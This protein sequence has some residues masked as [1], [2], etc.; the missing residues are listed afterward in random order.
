MLSDCDP[1]VTELTSALTAA[2]RLVNR[3]VEIAI[4]TLAKAGVCYST[5]DVNGHVPAVRTKVIDP[6]G[7]GDALTATVLFG[8]VNDIPLDDAV[9]LGVTAASLVL[10]H[11]GT[12][13]PELSLER[14]YEELVI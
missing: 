9:R 2:R 6:T 10:R 14:L 5:Q 3:G 4:I 8:L 7:S 1:E 11:P 12:V 13:L